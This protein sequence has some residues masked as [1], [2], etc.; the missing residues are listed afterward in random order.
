MPLNGAFDLHVHCA[1]DVRPRKTTALEL[2]R[3][4]RAAGMRGLLLKN[5]HAPTMML[6]AAVREVAPELHIFGGLVLNEAAG[7]FNPRAVEAALRMGA[8]E[9]WMPTLCAANERAHRGDTGGGPGLTIYDPLGRLHAGLKEILRL[10]AAANAILGTGHLAGHEIR[11]LAAAARDAGVSKF[12]VTH[13]EIDFINLPVDLQRDIGGPGVYFERCY[14]RPGFA[15]G[16][17]DFASVI[18]QV[19]VESTVLATDLGQPENPDPVGGLDEMYRQLARR[20]FSPSELERM[21]CHNPASLLG[22]ADNV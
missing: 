14:V 18:R 3:A 16:W 9:I 11:D 1:P 22:L 5:H 13:P 4:A 6:A 7:G 19:G 12:L 8:A 20:G 10:A 21:M 17:D 2:A 15:L